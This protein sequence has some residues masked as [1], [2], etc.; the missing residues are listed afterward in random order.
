MLG[1]TLAQLL[2][3][4][5]LKLIFDYVLLE[6]SPAS[7]FPLLQKLIE[8]NKFFSVI[9]LSSL[10]LLIAL[11]RGLFSYFQ[12]FL[13]SRIG[14]HLVHKL[15]R[16]LFSHLQ[17]LSL[18]FHD[19]TRSGELLTKI[20]GDTKILRDV[21]SD[22]FLELIAQVMLL[23][24]MLIVMAVLNWKLTLIA[25]STFPILIYSLSSLYNKLKKSQK[26]QRKREGIV[27]SKINELLPAI[28][29]VQSFA[30][31]QYEADLFDVDSTRTLKQSIHVARMVASTSR[32]VQVI[33]AFGV[34][35]T[36]LFG[37][38]QALKGAMTPG[39]VLIFSTYI[40]N[41]YGPIQKLAKLSVRFSKAM[42][43][44]ERISS[45][46]EIEPEI[47]DRTGAIKAK[48]L[49]GN[50]TFQEVSFAYEGERTLFEKLSFSIASGQR[51]ALV[52]ASGAGKS[53]IAKLLLRLYDIQDGA[54]FV[55]GLD[56]RD[57][58][59]E[60]LRQEIGIVA[61]DPIL[62]GTSIKENILY[63]KPDARDEAVLEAAKMA[64]AHEFISALPD[65]YATVLGERGSTLSGGQRQRIGLA[66]AII[67]E[68]SI[69]ILDEPTSAV[70]AESAT[71][72][73]EAMDRF[74]EGKTSLVIL[75]QFNAIQ[76]FDKI[77]VMKDRQVV[78]E[79][80]HSDLIA[81]NGYY[82]ELYRHQGL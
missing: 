79:G 68:P 10:M 55:D 56:I 35:T 73:H 45:L 12:I 33:K 29:L 4:W 16:E 5:P 2:N 62:F 21:F 71:L 1:Y 6:K 8:G 74:Q 34:S 13:T 39:D 72:I 36:I 27:A 78:E 63:G 14:F 38:L 81:L 28:S 15:R 61:Q 50:I 49:E 44:A 23:T 19:R 82:N 80:T 43:S 32:T 18:S 48:N 46:L 52:G 40:N 65:G 26:K 42:T 54:I 57:Y 9:L 17:T 70:D 67:K 41:M 11:T 51:V 60:S 20:T 24:G 75:H 69:L 7:P 77:I 58:Q 59:K 22:S 25:M 66:R 31:E 53:T 3:P 37:A 64:H 76:D 47:I 30:R